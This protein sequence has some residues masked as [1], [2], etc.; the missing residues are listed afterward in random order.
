VV[1]ELIYQPRLSG[2]QLLSASYNFV[3]ENWIEWFIPNLL[4]LFGGYLLLNPLLLVASS[5]PL[6]L[7]LFAVYTGVSLFLAYFM[8][9]RGILFSLLQGTSRRGRLYKY[10]VGEPFQGNPW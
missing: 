5:L 8:I 9:F 6:A 2:L 1:P 3:I 4:I 7:Q 10:R